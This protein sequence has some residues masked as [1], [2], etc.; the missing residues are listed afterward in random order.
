MLDRPAIT[1]TGWSRYLVQQRHHASLPLAAVNQWPA[2]EVQPQWVLW[3]KVGTTAECDIRLSFMAK[4]V[5]RVLICRRRQ[6]I[7]I[8]ADAGLYL[9]AT[10]H[11]IQRILG[12]GH[13]STYQWY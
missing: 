2:S 3:R 1:G 9:P 12:A 4:S 10:A 8:E 6:D 7:A 5:K 13:L 11:F